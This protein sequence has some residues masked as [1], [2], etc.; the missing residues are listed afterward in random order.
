[1]FWRIEEAVGGGQYIVLEGLFDTR[2]QALDA[3]AR[4]PSNSRMR[5]VAYERGEWR[6]PR[7]VETGE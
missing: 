3:I 1:M 2:Q 6:G 5:P 4:L 7:R